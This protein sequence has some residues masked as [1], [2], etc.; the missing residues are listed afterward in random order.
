MALAARADFVLVRPSELMS[1]AWMKDAADAHAR[2]CPLQAHH[3]AV[4]PRQPLGGVGC[5]ARHRRRAHAPQHAQALHRAGALL[6]RRAEPARACTPSTSASTSGPCSDSRASGG[7]CRPSGRSATPDIDQ[8]CNSKSN[9][10]R[11]ERGCAAST[12]GRGWRLTMQRLL[13]LNKKRHEADVL[14]CV[15]RRQR[16]E[17]FFAPHHAEIDRFLWHARESLTTR[18]SQ[19]SR[20]VSE[21]SSSAAANAVDCDAVLAPL[22]AAGDPPT[23]GRARGGS[24]SS[25]LSTVCRRT[26]SKSATPT[27]RRPPPSPLPRA[28]RRLFC[29]TPPSSTT[30]RA[31]AAAVS[32]RYPCVSS[33]TSLSSSLP[34][35]RPTSRPS[36]CGSRRSQPRALSSWRA[37]RQKTL[38]PPPP[39]LKL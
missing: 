32:P 36:G 25:R 1:R 10:P 12:S 8:L 37:R 23:Q 27:R 11:C 7:S 30:S 5:S 6:P 4:Q 38:P 39:P 9:S 33:S 22:K 14:R 13:N 31:K 18:N 34:A 26:T 29:V 28:A 15:R 16:G 19:R 17:C 2:D 20:T 21:P 35:S 24:V 3:Q